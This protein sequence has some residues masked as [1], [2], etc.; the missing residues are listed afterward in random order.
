MNTI[1]EFGNKAYNLADLKRWLGT[2]KR[3]KRKDMVIQGTLKQ[4]LDSGFVVSGRLVEE[5]RSKIK[6][7]RQCLAYQ[8]QGI[9]NKGYSWNSDNSFDSETHFGQLELTNATKTLFLDM[10]RDA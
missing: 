3:G 8:Q 2:L 6:N 7:H 5:G 1:E 4:L 9:G 10:S